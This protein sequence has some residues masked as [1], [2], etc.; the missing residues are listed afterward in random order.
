MSAEENKAL[1]Q[2]VYEQVFNQGNLDQIEEFVSADLEA[3][4][5]GE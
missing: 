4:S 2:R 5:I 3:P 1:L